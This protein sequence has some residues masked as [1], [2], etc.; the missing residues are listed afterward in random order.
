MY[1]RVHWNKL[2]VTSFKPLCVTEASARDGWTGGLVET[3]RVTTSG[4]CVNSPSAVPPWARS[5]FNQ[6][7]VTLKRTPGC[8]TRIHRLYRSFLL[9]A[10]CG[11]TSHR[12]SYKPA[13]EAL[14]T[15]VS[16]SAQLGALRKHQ[17][18]QRL[19]AVLLQYVRGRVGGASGACD[20][21][22]WVAFRTSVKHRQ[23]L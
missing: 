19:A 5:V 14:E 17:H 22:P 2:S 23:E 9:R 3:K 1:V 4:T 21:L 6:V 12:S 20:R 13:S 8:G 10:R 16:C 7:R 18:L 11:T 15:I